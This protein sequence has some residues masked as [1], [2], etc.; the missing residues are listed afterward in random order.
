MMLLTWLLYINNSQCKYILIRYLFVANLKL[1]L[2][3]LH[4]LDFS[5]HLVLH[6]VLAPDVSSDSQQLAANPDGWCLKM[7]TTKQ[8]SSSSTYILV[9]YSIL[10]VMTVL[11]HVLT[12]FDNNCGFNFDP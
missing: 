10:C 6:G 11:G 8:L 2:P 12:I 9:H 5:E 1:T 3:H 7:P 4:K